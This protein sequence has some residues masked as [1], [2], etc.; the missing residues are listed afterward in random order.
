MPS[1]LL[2]APM[3]APASSVATRS[4]ASLAGT[5]GFPGEGRAAWAV[6]SSCSGLR[7]VRVS[8]GCGQR[9]RWGLDSGMRAGC[10]QGC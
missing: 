3:V 10:W 4:S 8:S 5:P 9:A 6:R 1:S 2:C 7:S